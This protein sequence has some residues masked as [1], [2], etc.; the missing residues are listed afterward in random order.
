MKFS[1]HNFPVLYS[2]KKEDTMKIDELKTKF[3]R[4]TGCFLSKRDVGFSSKS[5]FVK[6]CIG[7]E[8]PK[9]LTKNL[10]Q[11]DPLP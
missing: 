1:I 2:K 11:S 4:G 7:V 10:G 9:T 5:I 6:L 3:Q 8:C